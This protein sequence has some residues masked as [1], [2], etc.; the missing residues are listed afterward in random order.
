M[1]ELSL[2]YGE[3]GDGLRVSAKDKRTNYVSHLI[4]SIAGEIGFPDLRRGTC[5]RRHYRG[6]IKVGSVDCMREFV[7]DGICHKKCTAD[8]CAFLINNDGVLER[9]FRK[10]LCVVDEPSKPNLRGMTAQIHSQSIGVS[11]AY[12]TYAAP[13]ARRKY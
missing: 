10:E 8:Y 12:M 1:G 13:S 3:L 9:Y 4:G 6:I 2:R 11:S 7:N 5:N